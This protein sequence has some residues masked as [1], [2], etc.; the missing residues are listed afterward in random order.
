ML[1]CYTAHKSEDDFRNASE[2]VRKDSWISDDIPSLLQVGLNPQR[3]P[4]CSP[5]WRV[6]LYLVKGDSPSPKLPASFSQAAGLY[7]QLAWSPTI[8][9]L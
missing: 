9:R 8:Q 3:L 1:M 7:C 6:S 4:S 5:A 2:V